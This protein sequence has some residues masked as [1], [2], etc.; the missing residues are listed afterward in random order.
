VGRGAWG[1]GH[2]V[3]EELIY[4]ITHNFNEDRAIFISEY[5]TEF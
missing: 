1:M 3:W 5:K 4:Y 2:G